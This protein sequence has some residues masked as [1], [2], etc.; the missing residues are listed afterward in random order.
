MKHFSLFFK[1][2][3]G[4]VYIRIIV[5]YLRWFYYYKIKK[6]FQFLKIKNGITGTINHNKQVFNKFPLTDFT[7]KRMDRLIAVIKSLELIADQ[8]NFL[9]IGPR[10]ESDIYKIIYNYPQSKI[11]AIDIIS[12]SP[13]IDLQD[14][15]CTNFNSNS[16]ECI[17]SGWVLKYSTNK[18]KMMN[19]MIRVV[20][21][22]GLIAIGIEYLDDK[23][24]NFYKKKRE[25]NYLNPNDNFEEINSVNDI[26]MI[27]KKISVNY[28][29]IYEYDALLKN[30]KIEEI[31][32]ITKLHSTQI[33]ICFQIFK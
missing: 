21:N 32:K 8:S 15:H 29:I 28:R 20:K 18:E 19:E 11:N 1:S 27:L 14:A 12:Y 9:I 10:T 5:G 33:M 31:Y 7:M 26:E 3:Y 23:L 25:V 13:L 16:F 22:E 6:S 24:K 4:S 17:I 2:L 30:K